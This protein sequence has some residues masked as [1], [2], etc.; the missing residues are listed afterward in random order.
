[1]RNSPFLPHLTL[2]KC[3]TRSLISQTLR[4]MAEKAGII[5]FIDLD[6]IIVVL[7]RFGKERKFRGGDSFESDVGE[8]L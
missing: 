7:E 5:F 6:Q 2:L 4:M 1:M 3:R 8:A